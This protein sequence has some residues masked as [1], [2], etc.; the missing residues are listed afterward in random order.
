MAIQDYK[1]FKQ[2]L[3]KDWY[4]QG[5]SA[6]PIFLSVAAASGLFMKKY[7]GFNYQ[8]F[9]FNYRKDYGEMAYDPQDLERIYKLVKN[10]LIAQPDYL[11]VVKREHHRKIVAYQPFLQ[12]IAESDLK[13][14]T[15]KRVLS[16]LN[17]LLLAQRD[18]VGV[19]HI[20]DAIGLEIEGEFKE[21]LH[22][23]NPALTL[24][25]FNKLFIQLITPSRSSFVNQE[26]RELLAIKGGIKNIK[27]LE[28][29]AAR[30]FWLTNSYA[31][32]H[33]LTVADFRKK[34]INSKKPKKSQ[35][36]VPAHDLFYRLSPDLKKMVKIINFCAV[37][38]DER[39]A[40]IFKNIGYLDLILQEIA[41]RLHQPVERLYYLGFRES[42]SLQSFADLYSLLPELRVRQRGC[43]VI[44]DNRR[45]Q[46]LSGAEYLK[47]MKG[48]RSLLV[49]LRHQ[50]KDLHGTVANVGTA[51]GKVRIIK[52]IKSLKSFLP[53][54]ILVASMTRP[55]F[56]IAIKKAAAIVTDEGGITCHAAII[57]RELN[58]PAIISTKL[59]TKVLRDGMLVEVKANHGIVR[60]LSAR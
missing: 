60:I 51:R 46:I 26:E 12:I 6:V 24:K 5:F 36:T 7:L 2:Y 53:G 1:L 54:E 57:A 30:Y 42:L 25:E 47:L 8:H 40:L 19:S 29:H 16:L 23:E 32:S 58:L 55:E 15:D 13:S 44:M 37:W 39:K 43:L 18:N 33:I 11:K 34:L 59:A 45:D 14:F 52:T 50:A 28:K 38:Q 17:K 48:R 56:I 9:F 10:K 31:G 20:I 21:R 35:P 49:G 27:S 22:R 41:R 4:I 3:E